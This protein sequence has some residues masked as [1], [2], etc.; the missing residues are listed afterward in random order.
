MKPVNLALTKVSVTCQ[1]LLKIHQIEYFTQ[2]LN[3]VRR[4]HGQ[5]KNRTALVKLKKLGF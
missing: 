3:S 1:N 4:N 2:L 5:N